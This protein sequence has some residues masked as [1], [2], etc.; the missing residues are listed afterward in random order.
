ML[1]HPDYLLQ[2]VNVKEVRLRELE[3]KTEMNFAIYSPLT[4]SRILAGR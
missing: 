2:L 3:V 4:I 1:F